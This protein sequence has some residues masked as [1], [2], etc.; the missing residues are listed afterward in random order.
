[1]TAPFTGSGGSPT[2]IYTRR[3][4]TAWPTPSG[5]IKVTE[6]IWIAIEW[7]ASAV[8]PISPI[9]KTAPLKIDTSKTRV[10]AIGRPSAQSARKRVQS[11]RQ[12]RPSRW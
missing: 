1:M 8:F 12:K 10:V 9:R 4:P 2:P 3:S 11:D 5:T 6:A 7:A